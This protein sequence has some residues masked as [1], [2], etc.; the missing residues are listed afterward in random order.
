MLGSAG[1]VPTAL[2]AEADDPESLMFAG[3]GAGG[4]LAASV[5]SAVKMLASE[6]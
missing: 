3:L 5:L 1:A 4:L 6:R 2:A